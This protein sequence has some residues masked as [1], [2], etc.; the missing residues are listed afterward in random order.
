MT[1]SVRDHEEEQ[2]TERFIGGISY[3]MLDDLLVRC[4]V[5]RSEARSGVPTE[6]ATTLRRKGLT[7]QG[8]KGPHACFIPDND[9]FYQLDIFHRVE[10]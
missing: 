9:M 2:T 3:A 5:L 6:H 1:R 4:Q 8:R 7:L 10:Y